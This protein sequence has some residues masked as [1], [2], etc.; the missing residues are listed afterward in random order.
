MY[1]G[2]RRRAW[3][4]HRG[5]RPMLGSAAPGPFG[6]N[7]RPE[8][9]GT[10]RTG[11]LLLSCFRPC[12]TRLSVPHADASGVPHALAHHTLPPHG[13]QRWRAQLCWQHKKHGHLLEQAC[14]SVN[15]SRWSSTTNGSLGGSL[16]H[17]PPTVSRACLSSLNEAPQG[18]RNSFR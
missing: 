12:V 5:V 17:L 4:V 9:H 10:S 8:S 14:R 11:E 15:P 13:G 6:G 7:I 3:Q 2:S 1:E 16:R 18:S